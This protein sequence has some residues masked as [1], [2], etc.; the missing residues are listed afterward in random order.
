MLS[1][2]LGIRHTGQVVSCVPGLEK[3]QCVLG[4][5]NTSEGWGRKSV[6]CESFRIPDLPAACLLSFSPIPGR[7]F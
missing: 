2:V 6:G 5:A 7:P 1:R 3:G 4:A